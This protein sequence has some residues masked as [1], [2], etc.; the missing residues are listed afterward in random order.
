MPNRLV[1]Q[2]QPS[3]EGREAATEKIHEIMA[4]EEFKKLRAAIEESCEKAL[5]DDPKSYLLYEYVP[6][7]DKTD[8][9]Y[10][11]D[12]PNAVSSFL[13]SLRLSLKN[14]DIDEKTKEKYETLI[15][16]LELYNEFREKL[17]LAIRFLVCDESYWN[18]IKTHPQEPVE[19]NFSARAVD[20]INGMR[21][22]KDRYMPITTYTDILHP[23]AIQYV[24]D[25]LENEKP[26]LLEKAKRMLDEY[27]KRKNKVVE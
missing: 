17:D 8:P 15:K 22:D 13:T 4:S 23:A 9:F 27:H 16:K 24:Q 21:R 10:S 26:E 25:F 19:S 14:K 6:T 12:R 1:F 3:P 18:Y 2:E 20:L 5:R 7:N 11:T